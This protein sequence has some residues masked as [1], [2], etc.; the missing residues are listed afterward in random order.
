M[1]R[2]ARGVRTHGLGERGEGSQRRSDF[3][4]EK[5]EPHEEKDTH[6]GN[7]KLC[8]ENVSPR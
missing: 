6:K 3:L 7:V 2:E 8:R 4:L 5:F 1:L